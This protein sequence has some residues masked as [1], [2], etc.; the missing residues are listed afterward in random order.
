MVI[1][2]LPGTEV[3]STIY[4][5]RI[6]VELNVIETLVAALQGVSGTRACIQNML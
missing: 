3:K 5:A 4:I 1:Y 6:E 2:M